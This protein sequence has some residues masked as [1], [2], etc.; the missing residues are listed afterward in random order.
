MIK[1]AELVA[2][3]RAV[4]ALLADLKVER[5]TT[6][7]SVLITKTSPITIKSINC[8]RPIAVEPVVSIDVKAVIQ[9]TGI[10]MI[11]APVR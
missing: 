9:L 8:Q 4:R 11:S 1:A 10:K 2:I 3:V 5:Q 6:G 7:K